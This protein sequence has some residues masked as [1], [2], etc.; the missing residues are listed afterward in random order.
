MSN[1]IP[2]KNDEILSTILQN[3]TIIP[4]LRFISILYRISTI[5]SP[6]PKIMVFIFTFKQLNILYEIFLSKDS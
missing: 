3:E 6:F 5:M 4:T 2:N 1:L